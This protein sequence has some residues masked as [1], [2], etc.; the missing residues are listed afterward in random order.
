[1][2]DYLD[3]GHMS[4][5]DNTEGID[6][7]SFYILHHGVVK[8]GSSTTK[9]RVVYDASAL[10]SNGKSL[11][12]YL[13]VGPKLQQHLPGVILRF[14]LHAVVFN[15]DI[16]QMFRRIRSASTVTRHP[17]AAVTVFIFIFLHMC[18]I[19]CYLLC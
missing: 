11:N 12:D 17:S 6:N 18:V 15:T 5:V 4:Y 1:M 14:R 16:K 10:S 3:S 19:L 13:F 8:S 7:T 9:L 2:Q